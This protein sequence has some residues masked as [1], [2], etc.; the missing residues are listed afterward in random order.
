MLSRALSLSLQRRS[1]AGKT[2]ALSI[3]SL[4]LWGLAAKERSIV[5][6][7]GVSGHN[8]LQKSRGLSM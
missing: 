8:R 2:L 4:W 5:K 3:H 1:A 6:N 7:S